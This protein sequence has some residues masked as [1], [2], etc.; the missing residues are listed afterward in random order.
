V[1][2]HKRLPVNNGLCICENLEI[3]QLPPTKR[4]VT[5]VPA[6][7]GRYNRYGLFLLSAAGKTGRTV[8]KGTALM[9]PPLLGEDY[10]E[11]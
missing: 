3:W 10:G 9:P 8:V 5:A 7:L 11:D 1:A 2:S 6:A 4:L